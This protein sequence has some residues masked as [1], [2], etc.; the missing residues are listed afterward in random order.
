MGMDTSRLVCPSP[1]VPTS[2]TKITVIEQHIRSTQTLPKVVNI[3]FY[4]Y[5]YYILSI[6]SDFSV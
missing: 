2:T 6:E 4:L 1:D 3:K 5:D